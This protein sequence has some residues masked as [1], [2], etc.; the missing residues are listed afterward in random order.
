[1]SLPRCEL[2][3]TG[4]SSCK[5]ERFDEY[6]DRLFKASVCARNE[7]NLVFIAT[8]EL[9]KLDSLVSTSRQLDH[10]VDNDRYK[11]FNSG[12][13]AHKDSAI[14]RI[15]LAIKALEAARDSLME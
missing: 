13:Y 14:K 6:K 11:I 5:N 3:G 7:R 1:M 8:D 15:T 10:E 12:R 2:C 9:S 4:T